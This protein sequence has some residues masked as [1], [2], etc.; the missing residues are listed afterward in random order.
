[1]ARRR[2]VDIGNG[3]I[4]NA[5]TNNGVIPGPEIRV[6]QNDTAIVHFR[7]E[8]APTGTGSSS[9]IGA[10]ACPSPGITFGETSL[11]TFT[12]PRQLRAAPTT[13]CGPLSR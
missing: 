6:R 2:T 13:R 12:N 8:P 10:T 1:M 3:I 5:F 7:N 11:Y 9:T 4:A